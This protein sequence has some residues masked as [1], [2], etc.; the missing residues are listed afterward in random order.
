MF[1]QRQRASVSAAFDN[2]FLF[3]LQLTAGRVPVESLYRLLETA[4]PGGN[5]IGI[6]QKCL[7]S[8]HSVPDTH[9]LNCNCASQDQSAQGP[10]VEDFITWLRF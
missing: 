1:L 8:H 7:S 6:D 4:N 10:G 3:C 5:R 9:F 2:S